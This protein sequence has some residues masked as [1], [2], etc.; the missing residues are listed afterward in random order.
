MPATGLLRIFRPVPPK[1]RRARQDERGSVL[2]YIFIAI[3]VLAALTFAVSRSGREGLSTVDREKSDLQATQLLDYTGM[4]RRAL[5]TMKVDGAADTSLCFDSDQWGNTAYQHGGC[6]DQQNRVFSLKGGGA[7]FQQPAQALL[8]TRFQSEPGWGKWHF[9]GLNRIKG[10]GGD[11]AD[12]E[13]SELLLTLPYIRA[14]TCMALNKRLKIPNP[15]TMPEGDLDLG[16]P[17]TGEFETGT[18]LD[19]P[20]LN[21]KRSGCFKA[22]SSPAANAHVFFAVLVAR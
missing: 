21:G 1:I 9:S 5:Q 6:S 4:I 13:C 17:F 2:I 20:P 14:E 12:P 11:C 22:V 7:S 3:A 8:D 18:M 15:D 19:S 10:V 16:T